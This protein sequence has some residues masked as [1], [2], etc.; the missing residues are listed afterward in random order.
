MSTPGPWRIGPH[1]IIQSRGWSI[2]IKDNS[3]IAYVLG[4]KNAELKS[5]ACLIASAPELLEALKVLV[6]ASYDSVNKDRYAPYHVDELY[7]ANV[8]IAKAEGE[9]HE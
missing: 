6:K 8:A 3:A 9:N 7:R 1:Q 4:E 5:N 2:R